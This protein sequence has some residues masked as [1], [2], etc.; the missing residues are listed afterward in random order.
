MPPEKESPTIPHNMPAFP[1][2]TP[3][4]TTWVLSGMALIGLNAYILQ[5]SSMSSL[6]TPV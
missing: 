5:L 2:T 3:K 1:E 4:H 6:W